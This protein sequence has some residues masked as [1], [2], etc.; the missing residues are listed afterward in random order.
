MSFSEPGLAYMPPGRQTVRLY[1]CVLGPEKT[2]CKRVFG[3]SE[4]VQGIQYHPE[5]VLYVPVSKFI[6]TFLDPTIV[7]AAVL[8]HKTIEVQTTS[9]R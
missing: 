5:A 4:G 3:C 2:V 7:K 9:D 8:E 6:P 1:R